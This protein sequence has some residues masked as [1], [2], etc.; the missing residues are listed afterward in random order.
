M[1]KGK[2]ITLEQLIAILKKEFAKHI[3]EENSI[4]IPEILKKHFED[5]EDWSVWKKYTYID[6]LKK[7]ISIVRRQGDCFIINKS[8]NYFVIKTQDE[9]DYYKNILTKDIVGMKKSI[10]KADEWVEE[11][12]WKKL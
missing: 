10:K 5:Y 2:L 11:K 6:I 7:G 1:Y 3:G 8:G 9:A 4:T 12:K